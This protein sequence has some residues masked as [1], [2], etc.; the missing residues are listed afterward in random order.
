MR[1]KVIACEVLFRELS[2]CA[3][4]ARSEVDLVFLR[5]GLHANPETL[6]AYV[7]A[8]VDDTD[9][10]RYQAIALG[11][12]LCSNGV[13]GVRARGIPLVMARA[14]DCITLLLG[15]KERYAE[16]FSER[17]GTYY[18]TGGW[19]ERGDDGVPRRPEDG[20]GLEVSFDEL[21]RK[22]GRDNAEYLW[23][24]KSAWIKHYTHAALIDTQ[25]GT[26]EEYRRYTQRIAQERGW[27]YCEIAG[28]L[29][30]M[31]ALVDGEWDEGRFLVTPP[32]DEIAPR[33]GPEIVVSVRAGAG[34]ET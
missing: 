25:L 14:H 23:E 13:A 17:P 27:Q 32:G 5:Q 18:Y 4:R 34:A 31:Q 19:I 8:Q 30:L 2:L 21:V 12:A 24:F 29:S 1:I 15:S 11:Y 7:Q 16:W 22:Y 9:E 28:D 20:A 26:T 33:V 10:T 3:A 6:R